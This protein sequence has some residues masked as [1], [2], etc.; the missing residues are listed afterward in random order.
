MGKQLHITMLA[1][2]A[3]VVLVTAAPASAAWGTIGPYQPAEAS[4]L[5]GQ[6]IVAAP[7]LRALPVSPAGNVIVIGPSHTQLVAYRAWVYHVESR[8]WIPG[9][10]KARQ[11]TDDGW[12]AM[13]D[14]SWYDYG[15]R[16]WQSGA[17]HFNVNSSGT[18]YAYAEYYW[19]AD[20]FVGAGGAGGFLDVHDYNSGRLA[21]AATCR[22]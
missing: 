13:F 3:A 2:V 10:W 15:S 12:A 21:V 17:T 9:S 14:D 5:N 1:I 16:N 6:I 20:R 7:H 18:Y 8:Q 19:F 4:C 11:A 22:F